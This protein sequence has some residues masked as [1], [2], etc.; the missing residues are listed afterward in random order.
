M[1]TVLDRASVHQG[2]LLPGVSPETRVPSE[3]KA[4][5]LL[6]AACGQPCPRCPRLAPPSTLRVTSMAVASDHLCQPGGGGVKSRSEGV[7]HCALGSVHLG[8]GLCPD[9]PVMCPAMNPAH[10][11]P[12]AP[13][14]GFPGPWQ[15]SHPGQQCPFL[16]QAHPAGP[17]PLFPSHP[18]GLRP[19]APA[20]ARQMDTGGMRSHPHRGP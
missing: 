1:W 5:R 13:L 15:P 8:P 3:I 10:T 18:S 7:G 6:A 20:K 19:Q 16:S 4:T 17:S 12:S 9:T 2:P 14:A 11:G